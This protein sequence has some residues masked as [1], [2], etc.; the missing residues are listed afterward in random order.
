MAKILLKTTIPY[1]DDDWHIGR[2]SL[3]ARQIGRAHV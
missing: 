3:L 1:T 2:F